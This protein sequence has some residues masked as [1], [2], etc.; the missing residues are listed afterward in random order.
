MWKYID[1]HVIPAQ[2]G[3]QRCAAGFQIKPG[4]T[5]IVMFMF[6]MKPQLTIFVMAYIFAT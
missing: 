4:M 3:I 2:I 1:D 5:K 6:S